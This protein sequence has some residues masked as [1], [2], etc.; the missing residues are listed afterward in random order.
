MRKFK[1]IKDFSKYLK[2]HK[3]K[4][5]YCECFSDE[6]PY[7]IIS[8]YTHKRL[9][10]IYNKQGVILVADFSDLSW[11]FKETLYVIE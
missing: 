5:I 11:L 2:E 9:S 3:P 8:K 10:G 4:E 7:I 1:S 6:Y